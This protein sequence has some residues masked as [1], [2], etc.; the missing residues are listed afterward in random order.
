MGKVSAKS[1]TGLLRRVHALLVVLFLLICC[2]TNPSYRNSIKKAF[3]YAFETRAEREQ[4]RN[5]ERDAQVRHTI[6]W[7]QSGGIRKL[8]KLLTLDDYRAERVLSGLAPDLRNDIYEDLQALSEVHFKRGRIREGERLLEWGEEH[9][10][11]EAGNLMVL[12]AELYLQKGLLDKCSRLL[13]EIA[14]GESKLGD[15]DWSLWTEG[16]KDFYTA[17]VM[18]QSSERKK[19]GTNG[20]NL[21]T[22]LNGFFSYSPDKTAVPKRNFFVES[23]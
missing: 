23:P 16:L 2:L 18:E 20:L 10:S 7:S 13:V 12:R 6:V 5:Q 17:T 1:E 9:F 3:N 14:G 11:H 19:N 22:P 4:R 21:E 8:N 15:V